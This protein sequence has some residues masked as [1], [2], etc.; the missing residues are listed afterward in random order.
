MFSNRMPAVLAA[1]LFTVALAATPQTGPVV[2]KSPDGALEISIATLSGMSPSDSG[3][4]LA[5]RV[6]LRGK[7]VFDWSRLGLEIQGAPPLGAEMRIV[8]SEASTHDDSWSSPFGKANPI[9]DHY[10]AVIV[11][12]VETARRGRRLDIEARAYDDGVAF[13]YLIPEQPVDAR[14]ALDRRADPVPG[15][16]RK[17]P[18][19]R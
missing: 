10:N 15:R 18:P 16:A 14:N 5:Y 12:G 19:F 13:R 3:G 9:R 7:P 11:R 4:Q 6:S 1:A 2:L 17:R 8:S